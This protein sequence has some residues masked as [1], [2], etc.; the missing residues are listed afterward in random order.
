MLQNLILENRNYSS[1]AY[2]TAD[3]KLD[4]KSLNLLLPFT[5]N[6]I[7]TFFD[8]LLIRREISSFLNGK[9]GIYC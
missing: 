3:S 8:V 5:L 1:S 4:I 9:A 6:A 7:K 2:G